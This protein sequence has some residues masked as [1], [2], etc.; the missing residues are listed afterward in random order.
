MAKS[1]DG[2]RRALRSTW[3]SQWYSNMWVYQFI[4]ALT[5]DNLVKCIAFPPTK[6][7]WNLV[8]V[9]MLVMCFDAVGN[10]QS[11]KTDSTDRG[12]ELP[13]FKRWNTG[14]ERR[15]GPKWAG[16]VLLEV[17]ATRLFNGFRPCD[18]KDQYGHLGAATIQLFVQIQITT[19]NKLVAVRL[20]LI[21]L[22]LL[23]QHHFSLSITWAM[24]CGQVLAKSSDSVLL[25]VCS[26]NYSFFLTTLLKRFGQGSSAGWCYSDTG[27]H[28]GTC[29]W[30]NVAWPM[31]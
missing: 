18:V 14:Q 1:W 13:G 12:L 20:L 25:W 27:A 4:I 19:K 23:Y 26:A 15:G 22:T 28:D 11:G 29:E 9:C 17:V 31:P 3:F 8:D 5:Q 24:S 2:K 30:W 6:A 21:K 10:W 16:Y 7:C